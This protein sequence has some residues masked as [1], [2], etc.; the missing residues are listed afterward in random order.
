MP[1]AGA[2]A[3]GMS[4]PPA[5]LLRVTLENVTKVFHQDTGE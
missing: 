5:S 1:A 4:T 3:D 2:V